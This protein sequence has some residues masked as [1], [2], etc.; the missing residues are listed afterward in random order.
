[1]SDQSVN[2]AGDF[3]KTAEKFEEVFSAYI[4]SVLG[5]EGSL[6]S[7]SFDIFTIASLV[8]L[9]ERENEIKM[10]PVSPPE[11][12]DRKSFMED[13]EN[14]GLEIG[15]DFMVVFQELEQSGFIGTDDRGIYKPRASAVNYTSLLD[16]LFPG[17]PGLNLVA[18]II[19]SI[20]E[21]IS[22]RKETDEALA[23]FKQTLTSRIVSKE[24][25][26]AGKRPLKPAPPKTAAPKTAP[27]VRGTRPL[28]HR[29]K[30]RPSAIPGPEM[31]IKEIFPKT[32][33]KPEAEQPEQTPPP[34]DEIVENG[35]EQPAVTISEDAASEIAE[36]KKTAEVVEGTE[37]VTEEPAGSAVPEPAAEEPESA[38]DLEET[39]V[40]SAPDETFP[41]VS[42]SSEEEAFAETEGVEEEMHAE[43]V[44]EDVPAGQDTPAA[45]HEEEVETESVVRKGGDDKDVSEKESAADV[46]AENGADEQVAD[47]AAPESEGDDA[48]H[49]E[50]TEEDI[51]EKIRAFEEEL[52]MICP[53]C[54]DG[55]IIS[56]QTEKGKAFYSCTSE[57]CRFVSW[58][59][60]YHFECPLCKN[61]FLLEYKTEKGEPGLKCPRATCGYTQGDLLN[62]AES[63]S[64]PKKRKR[65]V[66]RVR[67]KR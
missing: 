38:E 45:E 58:A 27:S 19:Q 48:G 57:S 66:R 2:R 20:E 37:S 26:A 18:Y 63:K 12:Y 65:V 46:H 41:E 9:V 31:K 14:I 53:L 55:K 16:R 59:K 50:V 52:A 33:A 1:M 23:Y 40:A 67:K 39:A 49:R 44:V 4:K 47:D 36:E 30:P 34:S 61:P 15:D 56:Q 29:V 64:K 51:E 5:S 35:I 54:G 10:F 6:S 28:R 32:A 43:S 11:R 13:L 62:P 22:G 7:L 3:S 24:K 17:M 42:E 21:V 8:L 60:P 25:A